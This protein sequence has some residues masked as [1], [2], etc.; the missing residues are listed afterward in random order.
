MFSL[1]SST[2]QCFKY[3]AYIDEQQTTTSIKHEQFSTKEKIASS[4]PNFNV[5]LNKRNCSFPLWRNVLCTKYLIGNYQRRLNGRYDAKCMY[6]TKTANKVN[7]IKWMSPNIKLNA[8]NY[9]VCSKR[10][11]FII[12]VPSLVCFFLWLTVNSWFLCIFVLKIARCVCIEPR[13]PKG[14]TGHAFICFTILSAVTIQHHNLRRNQN[15]NRF[16][17]NIRNKSK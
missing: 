5:W 4:C 3:W 16:V 8:Q 17:G 9:I 6:V 11:L 15:C 13:P 7:N 10:A 2:F 14:N 1:H 12:I